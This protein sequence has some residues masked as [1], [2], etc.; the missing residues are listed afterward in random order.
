MKK[1]EKTKEEEERR[2]GEGE[3]QLGPNSGKQGPRTEID[4][5]LGAKKIKGGVV[6]QLVRIYDMKKVMSDAEIP[7]D[8]ALAG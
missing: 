7:G 5:I 6:E 1:R 4:L 2:K 3:K 8:L